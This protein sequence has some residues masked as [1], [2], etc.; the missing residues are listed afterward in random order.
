MITI[1][2][3]KR[4]LSI[5]LFFIFANIFCIDLNNTQEEKKEELTISI[6]SDIPV[7]HPHVSFNTSEA[8]ILTALYEGLFVYDPY[9]LQ[10][11]PAIAKSWSVV[12]ERTWRFTIRNDA[13]F[14]NGD[15]ITAQTFV[16]AWFNL[17]EP[18]ANY[19]YASLLDCIDGAADY[20]LGKLKRKDQVGLQAESEYSLLVYTNAPAGH[21]PSI[22][23][24]HAFAAVH[25]TQ[26]KDATW[27][28]KNNVDSVKKAFKPISSG[29]YTISNF[30]KKEISL[31][32]NKKYWDSSSVEIPKI[33]ILIDID[34]NEAAQQF[35]AGQIDWL[36]RA[37]VLPKIGEERCIHIDPMFATEYFFFK[38]SSYTVK[39][40]KLREALL[41]AIPYNELRKD[42]LIKATSLVFPLAGYPRVKG[43]EE[44][45]EFKAIQIVNELVLKDE[46]KQLLI[47]LPEGKY[48][49]DLAKVLTKAWEKLGLKCNIEQSNADKYYDELKTKE[50]S[51]GTISWIADF[52]DPLAFLELFRANSSLN[53]SGWSNNEFEHNLRKAGTETT[54]KK[55]YEY[56]SKAEQILLDECVVIPL[57]HS[58][59]VNIIDTFS[60]GGWHSNAINIHPFKFLKFTTPQAIPGLV[61]ANF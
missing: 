59:S 38:T 49:T 5:F 7:L 45:N 37:D 16:D 8:Q 39:S 51:L 42:H 35:N 57:S 33:K 23:C 4:L 52:A 15:P 11:V 53:D 34:V 24:H 22:L 25:K 55:R 6:S 56:L 19:P 40:K 36:L 1:T 2:K 47:K 9:T 17:L 60:I 14:E 46:E 29:S 18:E 54:L 30:S 41:L 48:Y 20:R 61:R 21:L 44:Y 13:K 43:V 58:L 28:A 50:Y 32:K 3:K 26:L 31:A 10:P 12:G 27:Y